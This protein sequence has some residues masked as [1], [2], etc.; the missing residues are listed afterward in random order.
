MKILKLQ[1]ENVKRLRAVEITPD[2]NVIMIGGPNDAGKSSVLDSIEYALAGE[3][4]HPPR[5]VRKGEKK[6]KIQLD[7]GDGKT[8]EYVIRRTITTKGGGQLIV[9][10]A[11]GVKQSSP[12]KI[13]DALVGAISFDPSKFARMKGS[14]Q[15]EVLKK[16]IGVDFT[17]QDEKRKVTY[18]ARRDLARD[19]KEAEA[20]AAGM[21]Y[22]L[23]AP[24]KEEDM[25]ELGAELERRVQARADN[26]RIREALETAGRTLDTASAT[27]ETARTDLI[28]ARHRVEVAEEAGA[29]AETNAAEA[30]IARDELTQKVETLEDPKVGVIT[31]KIAQAKDVNHMVMSN[32]RREEE[33]EKAKKLTSEVDELTRQIEEIDSGKRRR[34]ED[35]EFPIEGLGFDEDGVTFGGVPF[36]QASQSE[37]WKTS[38]AIGIAMNPELRVILIREGALL[39]DERLK[40]VAEMAKEKD[41]QLWIEDVGDARSSVVIEDGA[42]RK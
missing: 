21:D 9:E 5:P 25:T 41:I 15:S 38:I 24:E 23:E 6:A 14:E 42:V 13:L 17:G 4:S 36:E 40:M 3:G 22:F 7:L 12:Q 16:L 10:T 39:D 11:D 33:I 34:L 2:G 35:T 27:V 37:R 20:A 19:A 1:A 31:T 18:D 28:E 26:E 32:R 29:A 8:V 30:E